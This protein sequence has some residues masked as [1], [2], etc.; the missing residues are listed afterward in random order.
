MSTLINRSLAILFSSAVITGCIDTDTLPSLTI[1]PEEMRINFSFTQE[2]NDNGFI[3]STS[4]V[5]LSKNTDILITLVSTID[6]NS[7][8]E[9]KVYV[10]FD[11]HKEL[12]ISEKS[13]DPYSGSLSFGKG[14]IKGFL[15]QD[16]IQAS[17]ETIISAVFERGEKE[18]PTG[19]SA[20]LPK[21][22]VIL[23][24]DYQSTF[25]KDKVIEINWEEVENQPVLKISF[26]VECYDSTRDSYSG[27][28][29]STLITKSLENENGQFLQDT[30]DLI[31]AVERSSGALPSNSQC[32]IDIKIRRTLLQGMGADS[33]FYNG[34]ILTTE[35]AI[36]EVF[37]I[38]P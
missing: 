36:R 23:T 37:L 13:N 9:D 29:Y 5:N 33:V 8:S 27:V 14:N 16:V 15:I 32:K 11:E 19:L 30:N 3:K 22:P 1:K 31:S 20:V 6:Y 35:V 34:Y 18:Y 2:H 7:D 38:F 10:A 28:P 17:N 26:E 25:Q 24:P 4:N 21:I 12:L